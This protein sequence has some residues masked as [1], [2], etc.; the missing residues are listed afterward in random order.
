MKIKNK[1]ILSGLA[2]SLSLMLIGSNVNAASSKINVYEYRQAGAFQSILDGSTESNLL[3]KVGSNYYYKMNGSDVV[4]SKFVGASN[5]GIRAFGNTLD[6]TK[7]KK[8][9]NENESSVSCSIDNEITAKNY[10]VAYIIKRYSNSTKYGQDYYNAEIAIN[11]YLGNPVSGSLN[12]AQND[13]VKTAKEHEA[14]YN[15]TITYNDEKKLVITENFTYHETEGIWKSVWVIGKNLSP[16]SSFDVE[17][18]NTKTGETYPNYGYFV[19]A[20]AGSS[21]YQIGICNNNKEKNCTAIR[22]FKK[23]PN[24]EYTITVKTKKNLAYANLYN[25]GSDYVSVYSENLETNNE[26]VDTTI[27]ATLNVAI[28]GSDNKLGKYELGFVDSVDQNKYIADV[29]YEIWSSMTSNKCS[30]DKLFT[31]TSKDKLYTNEFA[32]NNYEDTLCV[33]VLEAPEG[34]ASNGEYALEPPFESS[35][36]EVKIALTSV[37][38]TGTIKVNIVDKNKKLLSG[39]KFKICEDK[40]CNSVKNTATS[41]NES[42]IAPN[43]P[44]GKYYIVISEAPKGYVVPTTIEEVELS[45]SNTVVEKNI[46]IEATT[47]VPDTLSNISKL[48]LICGIVGII[49]GTYLVYSNAKKQEEV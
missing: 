9:A 28:N 48:F 40:N 7:V 45:S 49:A 25:C 43:I 42:Y 26:Y 32:V 10:G 21:N 8:M 15:N 37:A 5:S 47:N 30:G 3:E 29:K 11:K 13:L 1:K 23:L 34:Y 31:F 17:V 16:Y 41:T 39:V 46:V 2:L 20:S 33:K 27:T 38:T 18:K 36:R 4:A 35:V 6:S 24:G 44:F 19:N 22:N 12:E 14:Y